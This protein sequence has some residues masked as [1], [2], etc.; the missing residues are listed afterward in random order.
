MEKEY[1]NL[2]NQADWESLFKH[3]M[4]E[5][6]WCEE[7]D[8]T[9][10][11]LILSDIFGNECQSAVALLLQ[12]LSPIRF[13]FM[14]GQSRMASMYHFERKIV[15]LEDG[16]CIPLL[17]VSGLS[18]EQISGRWN[19]TETGQLAVCSMYLPPVEHAGKFVTREFLSLLRQVSKE[20]TVCM[21]A[22]HA[23][24]QSMSPSNLNDCIIE[25]IDE[26]PGREHPISVR[27][28]L[29]DLTNAFLHVIKT[30]RHYGT[31]VQ[32]RFL[33]KDTISIL[34]KLD[35]EE[36]A[37][38]CLKMIYTA[39]DR[40][41]FP[42]LRTKSKSKA[43]E[44]MV[45]MLVLGAA[46]VDD[47]SAVRLKTC[48]NQDWIVPINCMKTKYRIAPD[49]L[50]AGTFVDPSNPDTEWFSSKLYLVSCMRMK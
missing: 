9:S 34:L 24:L 21:D 35:D 23:K 38:Q 30:V 13:A 1:N 41:I 47:F 31:L 2:R 28:L 42:S 29:V 48:I 36:F 6:G 49:D 3:L 4:V 39:G 46:L 33:G 14:D 5:S 37:K 50:H 22:N 43:S 11:E 32:R 26:N 15:P 27:N 25:M 44:F 17:G 20:N 12:G 8:T 10:M 19:T 40:V 16:N 7:S 18:L 45:L